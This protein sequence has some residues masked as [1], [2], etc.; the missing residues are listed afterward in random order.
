[1]NIPFQHTGVIPPLKVQNT[2]SQQKEIFEPLNP[3]HVGM[4]VCGPTVYN[5]PHIGNARP[6]VFFDVVK[7]Y[8][9]FLGYKV[10]YVRNITDVGHLT[11]DSDEG[12]DKISV[13][14]KLEQLEP[15][16]IVDY[17]TR[18]YF[19]VIDKLNVIRPNIAPTATGHIVEQIQLTQKILD[20]G[21]AYISEGSVY[22]DVHK[23]NKQEKYGELSGRILEDLLETTRELDGQTEKRNPADFA[24]WK[25]AQPEHLMRWDSP[26]GEG[27]PGWH[28][29]CTV[30]STKYLGD[31]FDIHGGGMDLMFPHHEC[32]IAQAKASTGNAPVKYWLHNNMI[33]IEG[34]KM[35]K[36][37]GNF[38]TIEELFSG[39]N[40]I[41]AQAYSPMT[42]RFFILQAHYRS[43]LD[44]TNDGLLASQKGYKRLINALNLVKKMN[45]AKENFEVKFDEKADT[46]IHQ[47]CDNALR[48]MQDDFNTAMTLGQLANIVKKIN[49]FYLQPESIAQITENTFLRMKGLFVAFVEDVL[50]LQEEK[51]DNT[52]GLI[53]ALL[54]FYKEAKNEKN[55]VIVDKIRLHFKNNKLTIKDLKNGEVD[56]AYE[57]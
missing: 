24:L 53:F 17:Y 44:F 40:P 6:A 55:Y 54:E 39:K 47:F 51:N 27:F 29:E 56:W 42:I 4:Y 22:F 7:R 34:A 31:S 13:R 49:T 35:S 2:L 30:M 36:S 50:G 5:L 10:R 1:M 52:E 8:L 43:T 20:N 26:W 33:T 32:E 9:Q 18:K 12:E 46:Q 57:E 23:Y 28:L 16:E 19:E 3:P 14:A 25:K 11:G 21:L 38:V 37:A 41:L 48:G 45:F 15:M